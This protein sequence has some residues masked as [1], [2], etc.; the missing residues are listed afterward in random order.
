MTADKGQDCPPAEAW[1]TKENDAAIAIW[2]IE[3][4]IRNALVQGKKD[5]FFVLN[6][7]EEGLVWGPAQPLIR[8]RLCIVAQAAKIGTNFGGKI[9][10]DLE[11][12]GV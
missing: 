5:A 3:S 7:F 9:L 2:R 1:R 8:D 4:N 10:I 11:L 12:H 6:P